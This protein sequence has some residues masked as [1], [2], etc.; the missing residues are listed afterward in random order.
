MS[1]QIERARLTLA[2]EV[3]PDAPLLRADPRALRQILLNLVSNAVKFTPE[4]GTVTIAL[5]RE[6]GAGVSL[7][8]SDSGIG[9]AAADIPK[10]M[11]PFAQLDNVYKRKYQGAGLGLTLVRSFAELHGGAVLIASSP[12]RGTTMTVTL[13]ESRVL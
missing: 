5:R 7:S 1:R 11:Q 13:P 10:L 2:I 6:P 8:V 12:G 3:P 4:G 9:I